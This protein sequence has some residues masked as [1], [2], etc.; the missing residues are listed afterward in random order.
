MGPGPA[1]GSSLSVSQYTLLTAAQ[2]QGLHS[3]TEPNQFPPGIRRLSPV[4]K[5]YT[6]IVLLFYSVL[7]ISCLAV[8]S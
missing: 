5:H 2:I 6:C 1:G 8:L 3:K 4:K 7:D